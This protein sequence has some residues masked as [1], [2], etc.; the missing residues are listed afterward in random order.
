M[1]LRQQAIGLLEITVCRNIIVAM[2]ATMDTTGTG[3]KSMYRS[4][5]N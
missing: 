1:F 4:R 3:A 5:K 2:L